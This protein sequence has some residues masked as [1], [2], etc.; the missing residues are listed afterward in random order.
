MYERD[1]KSKIFLSLS[2]SRKIKHKTYIPERS[3]K[4]T[5]K[6]IKNERRKG[7]KFFNKLNQH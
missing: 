6:A 2:R 1:M 5:M 7:E 3:P 4:Y